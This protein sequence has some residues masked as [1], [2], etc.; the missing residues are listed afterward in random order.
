MIMSKRIILWILLIIPF[1]C[2]SCGD[3]E[4][5]LDADLALVS[6]EDGKSLIFGQ[7]YI[8]IKAD[9]GTDDYLPCEISTTGVHTEDEELEWMTSFHATKWTK[10]SKGIQANGYCFNDSSRK[11]SII[12]YKIMDRKLY[13]YNYLSGFNHKVYFTKDN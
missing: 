7:W 11:D 3:E 4:E 8:F 2:T 6:L 5:I 12:F 10:V 1:F 9:F 13:V